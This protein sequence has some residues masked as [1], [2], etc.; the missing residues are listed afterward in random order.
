MELKTENVYLIGFMGSGKSTVGLD[1][2][3][4]LNYHFLDLDEEIVKKSGMSI[5][6]I[7]AQQ[8]EHGFRKK[9]KATLM[10]LADQRSIIAT[11]GGIVET[12]GTLSWMNKNGVSVYLHAPFQ[13]LYE[14][15]QGDI[16]RPLSGQ[17]REALVA[18]Y[19]KR[20]PLY[21][22]ADYR[23]ETEGKGIEKIVL[24]I[25]QLLSS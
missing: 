18:R 23:I 2:A 16:N 21:D 19:E 22:G 7:F 15:I 25:H 3:S 1:L 6:E 4:K 9:E 11:G 10:E 12:S 24:E 20:I 13:V 8:G 17:G 5:P 14:R